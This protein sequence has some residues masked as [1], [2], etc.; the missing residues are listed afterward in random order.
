MSANGEQSELQNGTVNPEPDT[1]RD[2]NLHEPEDTAVQLT[3]PPPTPEPADADGS[4]LHELAVDE[5]IQSNDAKYADPKLDEADDRT[6][7]SSGEKPELQKD[8]GSRTFTMRELLNELK[9]GDSHDDDVGT[10]YRFHLIVCTGTAIGRTGVVLERRMGARLDEL[11]S[12]MLEGRMGAV[13]GGRGRR[14]AVL[15]G[16]KGAVLGGRRGAVLVMLG[17][18]GQLVIFS[19]TRAVDALVACVSDHVRPLAQEATPERRFLHFSAGASIRL[20]FE[21]DSTL[22]LGGR[23]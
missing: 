7:Q 17:I 16:C 6:I 11:A 19:P 13:L 14:G 21:P 20:S 22:L 3:A 9:N 8:E 4:K 5:P 18:K 2:P 23:I 12:V 10:P 1:D 15:D